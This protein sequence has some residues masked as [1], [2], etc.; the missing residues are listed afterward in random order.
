MPYHV[1]NDPEA[2]AIYIQVRE[3]E[4]GRTYGIRPD[5]L[6]DLRD[7]GELLGVEILG[8]QGERRVCDR[9]TGS[10]ARPGKGC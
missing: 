1:T 9:R 5:V 7:D 6:L 10:R 8:V 3:G 4:V 2:G